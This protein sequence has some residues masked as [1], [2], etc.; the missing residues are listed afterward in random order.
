ML[1]LISKDTVNLLI[2]DA[3]LTIDEDDIE[4]KST[5]ESQDGDQDAA[6]GATNH[7][8]K[9]HSCCAR[10][11]VIGVGVITWFKERAANLWAALT[12]TF[13]KRSQD[14]DIDKGAFGPSLSNMCVLLY[15][16]V[17][18]YSMAVIL[19]VVFVF[20]Y[21][22]PDQKSFGNAADVFGVGKTMSLFVLFVVVFAFSCCFASA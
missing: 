18:F 3:Q 5:S 14:D 13:G 21:I 20:V 16:A 1:P 2:S 6:T 7:P 19:F 22:F 12:F 11:Q 9:L 8:S 4:L 10:S 17:G 15:L